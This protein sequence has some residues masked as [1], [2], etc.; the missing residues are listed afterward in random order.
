MKIYANMLADTT[1][2]R[3]TFTVGNLP[4]LIESDQWEFVNDIREAE[5]VPM[6][7]GTFDVPPILHPD[8]IL[9]VLGVYHIDDM[10]FTDNDI[11]RVLEGL[12]SSHS[13]VILVH[14]NLANA[15]LDCVYYDHM[16]N[17]QKA[18]FTEY[19]KFGDS[20][21]S[22]KTW[23][24][25]CTKSIYNLN[26]IN[27]K[28]V[29]QV[30]SPTRVY[31]FND[32]KHPRMVFRERL[33][34]IIRRQAVA[35]V[36]DVASGNVLES[37]ARSPIVDQQLAKS[38]GTWYP[39]SDYY[40]NTSYVSVYVET[41]TQNRNVRLISEKTFDPMVKGNFV[42]PFGYPGM[43]KDMT[44]VYGF[45]LPSW[46]D[47]S[48]DTID[49]NELRFTAYTQSLSDLLRKDIKTLHKLYLSDMHILEHNRKVFF[50]RP[51]DKLHDKIME[52]I[53]ANGWSLPKIH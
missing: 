53:K 18:Y 47:Y 26:I 52:V 17:R 11:Q 46:I 45:K 51:Y 37:N 35:H 50:D 14:K 23:T 15:R 29:K 7:Y 42:L 48:Y 6:H 10:M 32:V 12:N 24:I 21:L 43:I 19:D 36:S 49:D 1:D 38:G 8:Q 30:L 4:F 40:Y 3:N 13:R 5:I 27:K 41:L 44:E 39:V 22:S 25:G 9:L 28:P 2:L 33:L 20:V 34:E 31:H 16:F